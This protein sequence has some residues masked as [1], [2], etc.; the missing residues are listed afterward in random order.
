MKNILII[1][2][3]ILITS[4]ILAQKDAPDFKVNDIYGHQHHLYVDYLDNNKHVFIEFF[5]TGCMPCQELTPKVDV[6][7]KDFGC[8]YE[9][10]VFLGI[11]VYD[12]DPSVINFVNQFGMTFPAISGNDGGGSDIFDLYGYIYT[13][14]KI[15]ISPDYQ[16]ISD[17]PDIN[18]ESDLRDSL[19]NMGFQ[20]QTCKG[21]D[22][23]FYS[24]LSDNDSIT[25]EIDYESK[26][27][28]VLMPEGTDLTNLRSTF[29]NAV[30]STIEI[31]G[32]QQ[33]SGES[34]LDF[35]NG[36]IVY[37][38]TS[39]EGIIEDWTVSVQSALNIEFSEKNFSIYPNPSKGIFTIDFI[40]F[41]N[42]NLSL[43]ITD[44]LGKKVYESALNGNNMQAINISNQAPG[45]YML[46]ISVDNLIVTKKLILTN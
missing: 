42:K 45:I 2:L 26:S 13:P 20:M 35:T 21:N 10:I 15:L 5:N 16:I 43:Y 39:E 1:S 44:I 4:N 41:N 29:V 3:L 37:Q 46:N 7:F 14:Y 23:I 18:T 11:D 32:I 33:I 9:E 6:V 24:L 22:F 30:N 17:N 38:I 31:D 40:K 12:F 34:I 36:P 19:L 25:G 27:V 28:N 8:N